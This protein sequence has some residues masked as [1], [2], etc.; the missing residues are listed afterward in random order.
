[1][2]PDIEW[3]ESRQVYNLHKVLVRHCTE[4]HSIHFRYT[5]K[6][7][8][9]TVP[10]DFQQD[11]IPHWNQSRQRFCSFELYRQLRKKLHRFLI[12]KLSRTVMLNCSRFMIAKSCNFPRH[13]FHCNKKQQKSRSC[14][15]SYFPCFRMRHKVGTFES[16]DYT[17]DYT[18]AS[19]SGKLKSLHLCAAQM[20][21]WSHVL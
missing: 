1:M 18:T 10:E 12:R 6:N 19:W 5:Q 13:N 2:P 21:A 20:V 11:Q 14:L 15:V 4:I 9:I 7:I 8:L 16:A 3:S 17:W